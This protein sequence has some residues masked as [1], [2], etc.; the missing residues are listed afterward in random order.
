MTQHRTVAVVDPLPSLRRGLEAAFSSAG[1]QVA[2]APGNEVQGDLV[3]VAALDELGSA[4]ALEPW[5]AQHPELVLIA[6][7]SAPDRDSVAA[8]VAAAAAG[9][10]PRDAEPDDVVRAAELALRGLATLPVQAL[11]TLSRPGDGRKL[12]ESLSAEDVRILR[13]LAEGATVAIVCRELAVAE[14]TV[15]RRLERLYETLGVTS[16]VQALAT[17]FRA[18]LL[19]P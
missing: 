16:R 11:R 1:W 2:G 4:D 19:D 6:A 17:A 12:A 10:V 5:R 9:V 14:R 8:A 15:Y 18:G 3:V 7:L 13:L